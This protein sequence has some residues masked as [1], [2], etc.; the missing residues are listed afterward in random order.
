[1]RNPAFCICENKGADQ[2]CGNNTA[3]QHL[4]FATYIVQFLYLLNLKF[5]T[6]NHFL[7]LYSRICVEPVSNPQDM[8]SH[9]VAYICFIVAI[10]KV[11]CVE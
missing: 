8:F 11:R 2:L 4:C 1:M 5:Q 10:A 6:F 7:W 9:D 3:D